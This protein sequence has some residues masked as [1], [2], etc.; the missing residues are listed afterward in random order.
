MSLE[1]WKM[2]ER[3]ARWARAHQDVFRF[4]RMIGG[5]P[6][7]GEIYG[8]AAYDRHGTLA[9]RNPSAQSKGVDGNLAE[10]L[11]LPKNEAGE[12]YVLS[13]VFGQTGAIEGPRRAV[14]PMHLDLPPFEIAIVEVTRKPAD[15]R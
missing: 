7:R 11:D 6:A 4:G 5:D 3:A 1:R 2:L 14:D 9:L 8:F 15:A 13:S 12:T 10:I